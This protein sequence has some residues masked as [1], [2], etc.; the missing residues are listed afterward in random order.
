MH[1]VYIKSADCL[2]NLNVDLIREFCYIGNEI[3]AIT[4]REQFAVLCRGRPV[5]GEEAIEDVISLIGSAKKLS[6]ERGCA[7]VLYF[8]VDDIRNPEVT[9]LKSP[10]LNI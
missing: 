3:Y 10:V 1:T 8:N 7:I 6:E 5:N 4:G 9:E 2:Q